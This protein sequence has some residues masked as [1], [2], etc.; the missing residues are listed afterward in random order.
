MGIGMVIVVSDDTVNSALEYLKDI[1]ETPIQLG[2][3]IPG[4]KGV[5]LCMSRL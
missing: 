1:D 2:E 5:E 4:E 3:I